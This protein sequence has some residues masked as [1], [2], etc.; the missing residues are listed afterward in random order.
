MDYP[1]KDRPGKVVRIYEKEAY[2]HVYHPPECTCY[3]CIKYPLE[4]LISYE[5]NGDIN[6]YL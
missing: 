1:F 5:A 2:I 3:W 4:K 6:A